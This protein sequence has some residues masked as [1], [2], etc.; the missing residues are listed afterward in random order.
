MSV[1]N[2]CVIL[3]FL[4]MRDNGVF[5]PLSHILTVKNCYEI[6][7]NTGW[8]RCNRTRKLGPMITDFKSASR[9]TKAIDIRV[10]LHLGHPIF[11][12]KSTLFFIIEVMFL[13]ECNQVRC[14]LGRHKC[15]MEVGLGLTQMWP[16][17][18]VHSLIILLSSSIGAWAAE[19]DYLFN[20]LLNKLAVSWE[21]AKSGFFT[22]AHFKWIICK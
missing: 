11:D 18:D 14:P 22:V 3:R 17:Q 12:V 6:N 7:S 10:R 8:P 5:L 20:V 4:Y 1:E 15:I 2:K 19:H 16:F 21:T 9:N 13:Q